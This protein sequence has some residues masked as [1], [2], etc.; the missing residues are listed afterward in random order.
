MDTHFAVPA[1]EFELDPPE[2]CPALPQVML[3]GVAATAAGEHH[4]IVTVPRRD[5]GTVRLYLGPG[6]DDV[7]SRGVLTVA[8]LRNFQLV[9]D[10]AAAALLLWLAAAWDATRQVINELSRTID[11]NNHSITLDEID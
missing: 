5:G 2:A 1:H 6:P 7:A 3:T 9:T 10:D 11:Q 8:A 4:L